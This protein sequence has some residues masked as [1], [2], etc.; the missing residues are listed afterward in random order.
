MAA[1][2]RLSAMVVV[3]GALSCFGCA[4]AL[5]VVSDEG[6]AGG[7]G[8]L[9]GLEEEV[10]GTVAAVRGAGVM[11]LMSSRAVRLPIRTLEPITAFDYRF[12]QRCGG[13]A[14]RVIEAGETEIL[15]LR[16][17]RA[18][19]AEIR[20]RDYVAGASP[21]IQP[22][23]WNSFDHTADDIGMMASQFV[24]TTAPLFPAVYSRGLMTGLAEADRLEL[25]SA[26]RDALRLAA[27]CTDQ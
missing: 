13:H 2:S 6:E 27:G 19:G 1:A 7:D 18:D 16:H 12:P 9:Y 4:S 5:R 15:E 3:L 26:Y 25:G 17:E 14:F 10:L 20:I 23:L 24:E 11:R 21:F 22:G 8:A